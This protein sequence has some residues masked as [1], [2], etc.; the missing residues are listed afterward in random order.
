MMLLSEQR[1][2]VRRSFVLSPIIINFLVNGLIAWIIYGRTPT[3]PIATLIVDT[4]L[5]CFLIPFLTCLVVVSVVW[6]LVRQGDLSAVSWSRDDFWW[7]RWLPDRKWVRA[8]A[9]GLAIAVLGTLIITGLLL[10]LGI[11]STVGSIF[12]WFKAAY[13]VVLTVLI[14]PFLA[15][16][17]LGDV[18]ASVVNDPQ[19]AAVASPIA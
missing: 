3:I 19:A 4:L 8:L 6:Q 11:E 1:S 18:S 2:L 9:T 15:L 14:S 7:L 10:L 17:S 16:A 13:T 5:T 12:V